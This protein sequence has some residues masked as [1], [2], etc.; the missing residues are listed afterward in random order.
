MA[1][2]DTLRYVALAQCTSR[3]QELQGQ[4]E[5][6]TYRVDATG[7]L[8][9]RKEPEAPVARLDS[10]LRVRQALQ[11]RALAFDQARLCSYATLERWTSCMLRAYMRDQ[12]PGYARV[13]LEQLIKADQEFF[14]V[15]QQ[16]VRDGIRMQPGG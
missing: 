10:D 7:V 13:S 9:L 11:R 5:D 15:A 14:R 12:P 6:A 8:K 3:E 4:K 16:S 2:Q 1:E